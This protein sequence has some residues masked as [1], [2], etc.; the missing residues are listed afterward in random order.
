MLRLTSWLFLPAA[1]AG[2]LTQSLTIPLGGGYHGRCY[3]GRN[4][5][6]WIGSMLAHFAYGLPSQEKVK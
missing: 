1:I 6:A 3:I 4:I 5:G 2:I